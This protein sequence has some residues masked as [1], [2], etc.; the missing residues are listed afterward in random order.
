[1]CRRFHKC[2]NTPFLSRNVHGNLVTGHVQGIFSEHVRQCW[3]AGA[4]RNIPIDCVI[5]LFIP[6]GP[7]LGGTEN[8][9]GREVHVV[10]SKLGLSQISMPRQLGSF[11]ISH[12]SDPDI[13]L[14]LVEPEDIRTRRHTRGSGSVTMS[15]TQAV[16]RG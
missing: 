14:T 15:A 3:R 12:R 16:C 8:D 4:E 10:G 6:L 9:E 1:M 5:V 7:R 2:R 13:W 11:A